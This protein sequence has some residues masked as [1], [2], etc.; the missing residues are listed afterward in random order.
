MARAKVPYEAWSTW[1]EHIDAQVHG[2]AFLCV[3]LDEIE[4]LHYTLDPSI[5]VM[6][7]TR[8]KFLK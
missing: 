3:Y 2:Q 4:T 8:R 6:S 5:K 1:K 7:G